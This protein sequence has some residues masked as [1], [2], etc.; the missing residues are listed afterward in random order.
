[1][2]SVMDLAGNLG[3]GLPAQA[4]NFRAASATLNLGS[5]VSSSSNAVGIVVLVV[6]VAVCCI[7]AGGIGLVKLVRSNRLVF[8]ERVRTKPM[9]TPLERAPTVA[10]EP[11]QSFAAANAAA[12]TAYRQAAAA[13][14]RLREETEAEK[15]GTWARPSSGKPKAKPAAKPSAKVHP[16]REGFNAGRARR[17]TPGAPNEGNAPESKAQGPAE[18]NLSP[19]AC[20]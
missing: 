12:Q 2:G 19:E 18:S 20:P 7:L 13:A 4:F 15:S 6:C 8:K 11:S 5:S 9:A 1:M 16:D 14:E 10:P 17:S 3:E